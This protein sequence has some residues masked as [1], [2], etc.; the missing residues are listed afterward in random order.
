MAPGDE[1][2]RLGATGRGGD[3]GP[4]E[5][6]ARRLA[7]SL[8]DSYCGYDTTAGTAN[9]SMPRERPRVGTN[10]EV[11]RGISVPVSWG[12]AVCEHATLAV[13]DVCRPSRDGY[14]ASHRRGGHSEWKTLRLRNNSVGSG[15]PQQLDDTHT[16]FGDP[17][18]LG[19]A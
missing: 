11:H 8:I 19:A 6:L 3:C 14:H 5:L 12:G 13:D 18:F 16:S 17:R 10:C 4:A 2:R 9:G 1:S 15:V 7:A